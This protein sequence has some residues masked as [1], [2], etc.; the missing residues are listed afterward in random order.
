MH[1][2]LIRFAVHLKLIQHCKSTILCVCVCLY[3]C[4]YLC[5]CFSVHLCVCVCVCVERE[6][7]GRCARWQK[8]K[9]W[10]QLAFDILVTASSLGQK[11]NH[12]VGPGYIW[13]PHPYSQ[14]PGLCHS[15]QWIVTAASPAL[16]EGAPATGRPHRDV[17][18]V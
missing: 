14:T 9:K 4:R 12:T 7:E 17:L 10:A 6:K 2:S 5:I 13:P 18:L 11:Q 15:A 1:A 8:E 3:V 16:H